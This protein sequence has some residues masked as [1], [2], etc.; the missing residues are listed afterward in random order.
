[1]KSLPDDVTVYRVTQE[2]NEET[3][4]RSYLENSHVTRADV[5][6]RVNVI[7]GSLLFRILEPREEHVLTPG[8][9]GIVE[10]EVRHEV[11]LLGLVRF[12]I[13]FLRAGLR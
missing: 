10:P 12:R 11:E 8:N 9:P 1:M 6:C 4:P 7:T 5:W 2:F 13:E 3:V